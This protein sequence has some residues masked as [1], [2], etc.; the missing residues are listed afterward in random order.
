MSECFQH[1]DMFIDSLI[2]YIEE[3][4]KQVYNDSMFNRKK[5]DKNSPKPIV[6]HLTI[7][8][9]KKESSDNIEEEKEW[10]IV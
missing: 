3:C 5:Y 2:D 8:G 10:D 4:I 7:N 6:N 1:I 9:V